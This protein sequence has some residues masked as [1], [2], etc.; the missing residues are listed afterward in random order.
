[1]KE[2]VRAYILRTR[3]DSL[4][5]LVF[6]QP[7]PEAGIQVPGGTIDK[8]EDHLLALNR[9]VYE[10]SGFLFGDEW[11]PVF[12]EKIIHPIHKH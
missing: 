6:S 4:E 10:E 7:D 1:M 12:K 8:N 11:I 5:V 9:E 2:K 3:G